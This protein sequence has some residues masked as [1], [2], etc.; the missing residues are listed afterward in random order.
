MLIDKNTTVEAIV[1]LLESLPSY[2]K[3][4]RPLGRWRW[5]L[6][7]NGWADHICSECGYTKNTDVHVSLNWRYCPMCGADMENYGKA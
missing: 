1:G 5:E 3:A 6:A 7:D 4:S 2:P